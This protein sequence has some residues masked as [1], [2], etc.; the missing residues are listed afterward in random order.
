M[1]DW[2]TIGYL[3]WQPAFGALGDVVVGH[4]DV[5]QS[6]RAIIRTEKGTVPLE[7]EKCCRLMPWVDQ[8]EAI[9]KPNLIR[10]LWDAIAT[11]EPRVVLQSIGATWIAD[12]HW[13]FSIAL[14]LAA[15]VEKKIVRIE[16]PYGAF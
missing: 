8:P 16:V 5:E 2:T 15:D 3:H 10:E 1:L 9:A 14:H 7:P 12:G 11:Y 13:L 6:I 4:A